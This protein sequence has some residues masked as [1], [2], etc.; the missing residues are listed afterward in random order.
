[1]VYQKHKLAFERNSVALFSVP[2]CSPAH[3]S[4]PRLDSF[5]IENAASYTSFYIT[6]QTGCKART[7]KHRNIQ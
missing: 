1:M 7:H 3:S 6:A 4:M 5:A 2:K